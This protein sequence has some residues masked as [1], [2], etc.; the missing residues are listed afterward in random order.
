M[1]KQ[2][3]A[4]A[5]VQIIPTTDGIKNELDSQLGGASE[6]AGKSAGG[7]F[8]AIFKKAIVAAGIG[9]ALKSAINEGAALQQSL[10]GVET[11]FK[12]SADKVIANAQNA[13]KT[14]G[15]SANEY[16][17]TVTS[18]SASLLQSLGG[19][20]NAAANVADTALQDMSDN[21]NKFGTDMQSI[22]NAYQGFA[23]QNY[24]MLDN[25]KLGYGGTK[26]E[27]ERLLADAS[28]LSG[29]KYDIGNLSDVY[30]AIHVIQGELGVTGTTAKEAATTFTGSF[31]T[32]KSAAQNVLASLTLGE[33]V[34]PA[35]TALGDSVKTFLTGNLLPMVTNILLALPDML[36]DL[37]LTITDTLADL[38]PQLV[39]AAFN[40]VW[41]II[42][43]APKMMLSLVNMVGTILAS[44]LKKIGSYVSAVVEIGKNLVK[45]LWNGINNKVQWLKDKIK[46]FTQTALNAI[47][48]FFGIH[49]PSRETAWMGEMLNRGLAQGITGSIGIVERAMGDVASVTL[50]EINP[51]AYGEISAATNSNADVIGAIN[52][53]EKLLGGIGIYLDGD[54]LV[55][56]IQSRIDDALGQ[57]TRNSNRLALA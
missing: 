9:M 35:L 55:G 48:D 1:A 20:T 34:K 53:V 21:A 31:N 40:L 50:G 25:L 2:S 3:I 18:F 13:Y 14:A 39:E 41:A 19:D 23:K 7:K 36:P 33:D 26:T 57:N 44:V 47:K 45:G 17:E 6:T 8:G 16:M 52:R 49:S 29:Q 56:G 46:G 15:L 28:K 37:V 42:K 54:T 43:N 10:G 27:M 5:Y 30:E 51:M 38:S 22:Q 11:L 32:M 24:T 12:D 4:T